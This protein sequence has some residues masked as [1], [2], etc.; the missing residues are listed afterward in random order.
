[1][2]RLIAVCV[3][4]ACCLCMN[5]FIIAPNQKNVV[6]TP[7]TQPDEALM[8]S[9]RV[10]NL[11]NRNNVYGDDFV[12]NEKLTNLAATALRSYADE[13][14][15]IEEGIVTQY[16]KDLYDIDLVI[17]EDINRDMPKKDGYIYLIPRGFTG[18]KHDV[19]LIT[20]MGDYIEVI[21]EVTITYHDLGADK[22]IATTYIVKNENSPYEF[23]IL[24]SVIDYNVGE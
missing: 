18:Y 21:S 6:N 16:V 1:M 9:A 15:F 3:F 14:G 24:N 7:T 11:L 8:F 20:D 22:G 12:S 19:I 13:H 5:G 23:N 2:K 17:T 10:E 4:L